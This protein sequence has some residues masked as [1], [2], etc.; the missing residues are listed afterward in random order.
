MPPPPAPPAEPFVDE[1]SPAPP[2]PPPEKYFP[3]A[4]P[5][6]PDAGAIPVGTPIPPAPAVEEGVKVKN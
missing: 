4:G 6:V 3:G 1:A 5:G 2:P